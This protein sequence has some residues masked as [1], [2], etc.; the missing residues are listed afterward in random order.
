MAGGL[1]A[2]SYPSST[3]VERFNSN[4]LRTIVN[5][6]LTDKKSLASDVKAGD[7][8]KVMKTSELF[9]ESVTIIGAVSRP[10]KYQWKH[11]QKISDLLPNI[12]AYLSH[13]ADLTYSLVIRQ[14]DIGRNIEVLQFS[15]FNALD[16]KNSNDNLTLNARDKI[17][18]F[19]NVEE[20]SSNFLALDELALTKQELIDKEKLEAEEKYEDRMFWQEFGDG[21]ENQIEEEDEAEKILKQTYQTLEQ[22]TDTQNDSK[23]DSRELGFF[24]RKRLLAP[25]IEQLKRQ[26][27]SGEPIQMVEIDGAVKYPGIYPLAKG[28]KASD[29]VK[30]SGGLLESAYLVKADITRNNI[31]QQQA[32]KQSLTVNLKNVLSLDE[33][34]N[35]TLQS[36][37]RLNIH[38]IPAWQENHIVELRG[39][40]MFPGKYTI[41]RGETL[42]ELIRIVQEALQITL[43]LKHHYLHVKN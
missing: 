27:A 33:S 42:G 20:A 31:N 30:A 24:S 17:L 1:S 26:A 7:Y 19:S 5:I 11:N 18:I 21:T 8:I 2:S 28:G 14:K 25:V 36:K 35:I 43:T 10:G 16:N 40:F 32:I 22:L 38:Y 23:V 9:E 13:D 34:E 37:D 3:I 12:H 39:E 6:D 41:S 4:N 15:L 29:L